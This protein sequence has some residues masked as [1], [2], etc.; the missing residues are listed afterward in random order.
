MDPSGLFSFK[1]EK[2]DTQ[3]FDLR[4]EQ[5]SLPT[6]GPPSDKVLEG[7]YVSKLQDASQ[8]QTIMAPYNKEIL[9][10]GRKRNYHRLSMCE[11]AC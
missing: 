7:L 8:V 3:D 10:E 5:A 2:D 4:W 1:L 9:R 6:S 11:I